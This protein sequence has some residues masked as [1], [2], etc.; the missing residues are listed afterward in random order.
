MADDCRVGTDVEVGHQLPLLIGQY[1]REGHANTM[2]AELKVRGAVFES[3]DFG[4]MFRTVDGI[5]PPPQARRWP[6]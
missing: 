6:G 1:D 4:D 2:Q 5:A 3:Y